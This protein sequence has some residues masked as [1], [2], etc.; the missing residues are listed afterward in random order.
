MKQSDQVAKRLN[1][2]PLKIGV[3]ADWHF[4]GVIECLKLKNNSSHLSLERFQKFV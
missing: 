1:G 4:L 2:E 3:Y